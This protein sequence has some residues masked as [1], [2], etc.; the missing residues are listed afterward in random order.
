MVSSGNVVGSIL[1]GRGRLMFKCAHTGKCGEKVLKF[2]LSGGKESDA[3]NI[4]MLAE[5]SWNI[6]SYT[7]S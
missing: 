5:S 7:I 6:D 2:G 1:V 4:A 3:P